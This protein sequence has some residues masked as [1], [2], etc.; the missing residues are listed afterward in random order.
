MHAVVVQLLIAYLW[1]KV[2]IWVFDCYHTGLLRTVHV[3]VDRSTYTKKNWTLLFRETICELIFFISLTLD[4]IICKSIIFFGNPYVFSTSWDSSFFTTEDHCLSNLV[5]TRHPV[6]DETMWILRLKSFIS[7]NCEIVYDISQ[8]LI[9][10]VKIL[11]FF[12]VPHL[13]ESMGL[14]TI[15]ETSLV[16]KMV[17]V[18]N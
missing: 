18:L 15:V 5:V 7:I 16:W 17:L 2:F 6:L 12:K 10:R 13:Q 3:W 14:N 8:V 11:D 9:R 1:L 4:F